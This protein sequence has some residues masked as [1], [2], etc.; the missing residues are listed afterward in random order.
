[1]FPN[2][3][4]PMVVGRDEKYGEANQSM[5]VTMAQG[6]ECTS[7]SIDR[8]AKLMD[9]HMWKHL[10]TRERSS[11]NDVIDISEKELWVGSG[12]G[13]EGMFS[14]QQN[15]SKTKELVIDFR[16]WSGGHAPFGINGVEVE[17]VKSIK[18]LGAMFTNNL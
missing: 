7:F 10:G 8:M 1:M 11:T 17:R 5:Y 2:L 3:R 9:S 15:I 14:Y 16:K 13:V 18:F 6:F 12:V 4:I